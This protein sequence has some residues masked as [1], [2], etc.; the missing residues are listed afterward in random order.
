[1][2]AE[3]EIRYKFFWQGHKDGNDGVGLLVTK[4]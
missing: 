3:T 1:M 4:K 2:L